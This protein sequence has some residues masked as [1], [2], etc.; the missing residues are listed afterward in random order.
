MA[1]PEAYK[2]SQTRGQIGAATPAY[3][4]ATAMPDLSHVCD[5]YHSSGQLQIFNPLREAKDRTY[6]LMDT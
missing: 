6:I 3:T 5:L 4:T 2:S 1:T